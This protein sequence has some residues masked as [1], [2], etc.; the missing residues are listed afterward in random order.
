MSVSNLF[1][2]VVIF[3]TGLH[4]NND[5]LVQILYKENKYENQKHIC[6]MFFCSQLFSLCL[7]L[8][9]EVYNVVHVL[10]FSELL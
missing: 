6:F 5:C 7:M 9:T 3:A 2:F 8:L 4:E 10:G 1:S